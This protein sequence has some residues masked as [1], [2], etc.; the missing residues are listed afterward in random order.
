MPTT[1]GKVMQIGWKDNV[2]ALIISTI[3][4]GTTCVT[5]VRK[6]PKETSTSAKTVRVP[7]GD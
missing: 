1:S 6:R 4:N 7:F 3:Y 2:F 5:T